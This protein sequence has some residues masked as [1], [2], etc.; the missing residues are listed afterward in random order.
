MKSFIGWSMAVTLKDEI[1]PDIDSTNAAPAP[2]F[3]RR[4][5]ITGVNLI[6]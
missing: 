6:T 3:R 1:V 4:G 2:I 5:V